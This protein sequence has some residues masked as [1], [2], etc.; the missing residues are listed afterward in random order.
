MPEDTIFL[1]F[2]NHFLT[3]LIIFFRV[4][5]ESIESVL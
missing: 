3:S 4:D 5:L 2:A 1:H